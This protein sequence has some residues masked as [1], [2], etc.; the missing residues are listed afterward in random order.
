MNPS[1]KSAEAR[2]GHALGV[3]VVGV[4]TPKESCRLHGERVQGEG[5][6]VPVGCGLVEDSLYTDKCDY[7]F[8]YCVGCGLCL[9]ADCC[10]ERHWV[11]V[12][13]G[14]GSGELFLLPVCSECRDEVKAELTRLGIK[15]A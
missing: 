9:C 10:T 11:V 8:A 12:F 3:S 13:D 15:P 6:A 1:K 14:A 5:S 7:G 4:E 2:G